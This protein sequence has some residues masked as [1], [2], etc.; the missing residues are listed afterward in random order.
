[1]KLTEKNAELDTM[2]DM[3]NRTKDPTPTKIRT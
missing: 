2:A 3:E 1:M